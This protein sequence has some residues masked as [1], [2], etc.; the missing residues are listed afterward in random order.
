MTMLPEEW[1]SQS[2]AAL[3]RGVSR[4]AIRA[5]VKRARIR[6]L[7]VGGRTLVFKADVLSFEPLPVG[8][9]PRNRAT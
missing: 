7:E 4:Q 3:L 9:P 1:I 2:E 8:R 6:T 5:L